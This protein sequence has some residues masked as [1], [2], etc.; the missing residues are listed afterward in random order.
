MAPTYKLPSSPNSHYDIT[1][2]RQILL[3]LRRAHQRLRNNLARPIS[4]VFGNSVIGVIFGSV[5]YNISDSSERINSR[6]ILL[7]FVTLL[8]AVM[9]GFEVSASFTTANI[10]H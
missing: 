10:A 6:T 1:I 2:W 4:T 3:C 9:T 5:F 7:F 8:N